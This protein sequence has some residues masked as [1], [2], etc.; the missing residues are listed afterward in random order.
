[1]RK[2]DILTLQVRGLQSV[3]AHDVAAAHAYKVVL[4]KRAVKKAHEAIIEEV[5]DIQKEAGTEDYENDRK[6]IGEM[7]KRMDSLS[8][9]EKKDFDRLSDAVSKFEKLYEEMAGSDCP[10]EGVRT[11][12]YDVWH[13]LQVENRSKSIVVNGRMFANVDLLSDETESILEGVFWMP[14]EEEI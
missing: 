2:R 13:Q 9:E 1:M 14:P 10:M 7:R 4:L 8:L 3:T 12:P 6:R 11:V 5:K